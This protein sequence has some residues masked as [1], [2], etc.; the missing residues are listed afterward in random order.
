MQP[1]RTATAASLILSGATFASL[2]DFELFIKSIMKTSRRLALAPL[3]DTCALRKL[4]LEQGTVAFNSNILPKLL[5]GSHKTGF[6]SR[7][8]LWAYK[9]AVQGK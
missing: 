7:H 2:A 3:A 4:A 9:Q 8:L 1:Q 5:A 6:S